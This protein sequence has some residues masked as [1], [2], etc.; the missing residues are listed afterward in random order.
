MRRGALLALPGSVWFAAFTALPIGVV[1]AI[2]LAGRGLPVDWRLDGSAWERLADP[3]WLG[4][5]TRTLASACATTILC[6]LVGAPLA[7]FIARRR[8]TSR[9]TLHFLV[10]L[11]LWASSLA[12]TYAWT[13]LLRTGGLLDQ[14]ARAAGVLGESATLGWLY[15]PGAVLVGLVHAHLPFMVYCVYAAAERFDW[16]LL[17]A[18]QDL[19]ATRT[20][21]MARVLLPGIRP[22]IVAGS[23][24]VF[25]SS[26]GAFVAP[27]ILGGSKASFLGT[28]MR[29]QFHT[30]PLD[31]PLGAAMAVTVLACVAGAMTLSARF[32]RRGE[33]PS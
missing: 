6:L 32:V 11:P 22:G 25:V 19:G 14:G 1:A 15:T 33:R 16:R 24:L 31:Y 10:L 17:E 2:S 8:E 3:R 18:A 4:P 27:E 26:L 23:V 7:V 12:L 28:A 21:S 20:Q 9:R 5:A 29:E 30:A 13:I